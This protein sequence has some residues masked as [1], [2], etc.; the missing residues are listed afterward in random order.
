MPRTAFTPRVDEEKRK[1]VGYMDKN[2]FFYCF[3]S[4]VWN[5]K[6]PTPDA[7]EWLALVVFTGLSLLVGIVLPVLAIGYQWRVW[8]DAPS[9]YKPAYFQPY[10]YGALRLG[11]FLLAG[12]A[13]W[14]TWREN[15]RSNILA[16]PDPISGT[17]PDESVSTASSIVYAL[18]LLMAALSPLTFFVMGQNWHLP[19]LAC[20][21]SFFELGLAVTGTVLAWIVYH[22]AG[23]L[24]LFPA[25]FSLY[26]CYVCCGYWYYAP[27][28]SI[29]ADPFER[30][31]AEVHPGY[32]APVPMHHHT[33]YQGM[34]LDTD[35]A[36]PTPVTLYEMEA[37]GKKPAAQQRA[38]PIAPG[39][40]SVF[41]YN[42]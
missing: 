13:Q 9:T 34:V 2:T 19:F 31:L 33:P 41:G 26:S 39:E 1:R 29:I 8:W 21:V 10:F 36:H 16:P 42:V 35:H 4:P 40:T 3:P 27:H 18:Y 6:M 24:A 28:A 37:H 20:V 14:I 12:S 15:Y 5:K 32:G 7:I 11:L 30:F 23:I 25:I 22:V 17:I 38:V